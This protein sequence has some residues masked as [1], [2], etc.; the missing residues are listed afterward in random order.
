MNPKTKKKFAGFICGFL[1][2]LMAVGA[3]APA[4]AAETDGAGAVEPLKDQKWVEENGEWRYKLESGA[5]ARSAWIKYITDDG[6]DKWYVDANGFMLTNDWVRV[7]GK[8]YT[9]GADGKVVS[10]SWV[11]RETGDWIYSFGDG[12]LTNGWKKINGKEYHFNS[13]GTIDT[14][15]YQDGS[16]WYFLNSSGDKHF[17]WVKADGKWYYLDAKDNGKM[18]VGDRTIDG[19]KYLFDYVSGEM[20]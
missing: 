16:D 3:V 20:R 18:A 4:F 2:A 14:G 10:N 8:W 17:G 6:E 5:Y 9:V 7:D 12:T 1:A 13:Q 15:W 19:K 11:Q